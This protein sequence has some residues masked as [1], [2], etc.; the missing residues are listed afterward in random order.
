MRA[1][2]LESLDLPQIFILMFSSVR[3]PSPIRCRSSGRVLDTLLRGD[4]FRSG[5]S[6]CLEKACVL[7]LSEIRWGVF[8]ILNAFEGSL[9]KISITLEGLRPPCS[10]CRERN[11]LHWSL[12]NQ[13]LRRTS[14]WQA[15]C[16]KGHAERNF[17]AG[18]D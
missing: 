4:P 14:A 13:A 3:G 11:I 2:N 5:P 18:V 16:L 15:T 17:R 7:A 9:T 8:L 10:Q 6:M 1:S 12:K